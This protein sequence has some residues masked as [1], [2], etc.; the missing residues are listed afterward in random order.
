VV[1]VA[2]DVPE[3][4]VQLIGNNAANAT[5][6]ITLQ[7]T[8]GPP[9]QLMQLNRMK[10]RILVTVSTHYSLGLYFLNSMFNKGLKLLFAFKPA[11][12]YLAIR[13]VIGVCFE[14]KRIHH[15]QS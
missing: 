12:N 13:P 11:E 3:S 14:V 8:V 4:N 1:V 5:S 10:I 9:A 2:S 6:L 15:K 7:S